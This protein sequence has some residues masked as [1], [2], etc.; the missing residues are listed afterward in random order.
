MKKFIFSV[1]VLA[2]LAGAIHAAPFQTMGLLRT[3]DAYVIPH[4]AAQL[5][6]AGYYRNVEAP[7]YVDQDKNGLNFYGMLGVGLFDRVQ[8]DFFGGDYVYFFNAKVKL[9]EET[10]KWPQIAIGMDNI[11]SPVNKRRAQDYGPYFYWDN[12]L[13]QRVY[14]D[15]INPLNLGSWID[16]PDKTDYEYYSGYAVASKQVVFG[17]VDWM[18][19]LGVGMNRYTGQ[20]PRSRWFSGFFSSIEVSPFDNFA[21]Q[22]EYDGKDFNAG[23]KYSYKNFGVRLGAEALEDLAKGSEGNGYQN[24]YRV[25][26]GLSYMF[27]KFSEKGAST[28]PN[29]S[30]YATAADLEPHVVPGSQVPVATTDTGS[31]DVAIITPGSQIPTPGIVTPGD[32]Y[33]T[34]SPEAKDLLEELRLLRLERQKAQK[35][36]EDLR[37]WL[38]ELKEENQ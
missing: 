16:H 12:D 1:I 14:T 11:L 36:L 38:Q 10:A 28:R 25:A 35:A 29:L 37:N 20:V 15:E 27:D 30:L 7:S 32:E 21:L 23:V 17:G 26:L 33:K 31:G 8:L 9:L 13:E 19:N 2:A 6:L 22:A 18:F 24:N 5:V 3:P 34:L 4:K